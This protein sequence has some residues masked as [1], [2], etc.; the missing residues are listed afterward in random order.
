MISI[1]EGEN[2]LVENRGLIAIVYDSTKED[3][4]ITIDLDDFSHTIQN[5]RQ[6]LL[7]RKSNGQLLYLEIVNSIGMV[8]FINFL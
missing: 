8:S 4:S 2:L 6:M 1:N 3:S 5:P 7:H